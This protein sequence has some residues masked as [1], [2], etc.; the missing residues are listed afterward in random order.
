MYTYWWAF[1]LVV[2]LVLSDMAIVT[3]LRREF[4][5]MYGSRPDGLTVKLMSGTAFVLLVLGFTGL[6]VS[7]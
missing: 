7:L 3:Q 4:A 2:G 1:V 5:G 6:L